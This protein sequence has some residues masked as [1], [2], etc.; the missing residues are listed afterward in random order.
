ME[1]HRSHRPD[2]AATTS[3]TVVPATETAAEPASSPR[4]VIYAAL[5]CNAAI[6]LAKFV[7]A[8]LSGSAA[9]AAEGVHSTVDMGNQA[10]LLYGLKRAR[11]PPDRRFPFGYGKEVYF[12]CFVVAIQVFTVGAG[13]ALVRGRCAYNT[14]SLGSI[15]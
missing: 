7:A 9:M 15:S 6:A 3:L 10:L 2:S 5:A 1:G 8:A 12:W 4:P 14:L 11:R 13:A